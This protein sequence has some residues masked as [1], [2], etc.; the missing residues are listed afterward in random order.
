MPKIVNVLVE[1]G[2]KMEVTFVE[3]QKLLLGPQP[4]LFRLPIPSPRGTP[5][6][7]RATVELKTPLQHRPSKEPVA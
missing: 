4:E 7:N 1:F 3:M 6:K 2:R 5:L